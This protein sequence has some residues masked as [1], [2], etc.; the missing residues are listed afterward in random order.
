MSIPD[1]SVN[2]I[3]KS[4][5]LDPVAPAVFVD[6]E[7]YQYSPIYTTLTAIQLR[8]QG[9]GNLNLSNNPSSVA[10]VG[11][12]KFDN[13]LVLSVIEETESWMD[14]FLSNLYVMP[15]L[16]RHPILH[17]IATKLVCGELAL[18]AFQSKL[19]PDQSSDEGFGGVMR[20]IALNDFQKLFNGTG[21]QV[22][23][24][25]KVAQN[26]PNS[27]QLAAKFI[28]LPGERLKSFIGHDLDND[29]IPDT[30]LWSQAVVRQNVIVGDVV[31]NEIEKGVVT[32][33]SPQVEGRWYRDKNVIN[34][35]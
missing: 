27:V 35:W 10:S 32:R 12:S 23:S 9:R 30:N 21:I 29:N 33:W 16:N 20:E 3:G 26:A 19:S 1:Y 4:D 5:P 22:L 13:R 25:D 6:T 8:M 31:E 11:A 34:W 24:P 14:T 7:D 2:Y 15:L 17:S 28:Y 18:V